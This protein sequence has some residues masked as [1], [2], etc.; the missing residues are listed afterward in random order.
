[1]EFFVFVAMVAAVWWWRKRRKENKRPKKAAIPPPAILATGERL[2]LPKA[3]RGQSIRG[4]TA[5]QDEIKAAVG[6][7]PL[8]EA[9]QWGNTFTA[10]AVIA[11]ERAGE[12]DPVI[13]V[14]LDGV[15]APTRIGELKEEVAVEWLPAALKLE[16]KGRVARTV[17]A[18]Y[19]GDYGVLIL[20]HLGDPARAFFENLPPSGHT[21]VDSEKS[22]QV[23]GERDYLDALTS[24]E[25]KQYWATLVLGSEITTGKYA[26]GRYVDVLIDGEKVGY[27]TPVKSADWS[28]ALVLGKKIACPARVFE[29]PKLHP[30][31][32]VYLP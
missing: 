26:G 16:E 23:Q 6:D 27:L 9:G 1:M 13:G 3:P 12:A 10:P 2:K 14:Y 29:G 24:R 32:V 25:G 7:R 11:V 30:E 19:Q 4:V 21:L 5:Y 20:L 22:A 8:A 31:V 28:P 18:F 17:A 15:D